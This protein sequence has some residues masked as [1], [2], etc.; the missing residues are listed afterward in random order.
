VNTGPS[1]L[2]AGG[3]GAGAQCYDFKNIFAEKLA[4]LT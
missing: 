1:I 2:T 3:G 4:I